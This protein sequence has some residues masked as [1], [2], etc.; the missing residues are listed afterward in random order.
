MPSSSWHAEGPL[1][2]R[3]LEVARRRRRPVRGSRGLAAPPAR[4]EVLHALPSMP[5]SA[6]GLN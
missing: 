6:W 1:A 2:A 5:A 3:T 4:F